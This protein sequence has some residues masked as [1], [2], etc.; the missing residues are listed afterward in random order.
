MTTAFFSQSVAITSTMPNHSLLAS[1][2]RLF[3][4]ASMLHAV[5]AMTAFMLSM[6][7]GYSLASTWG[8]V[9][10]H[11][12]EFLHGTTVAFVAG[13]MLLAARNWSDVREIEGKPLLALTLLWLIPRFLHLYPEWV[14]ATF[15]L[16]ADTL[17]AFLLT[18]IVA[19][20]LLQTRRRHAYATIELLLIY[21]LSVMLLQWSVSGVFPELQESS[22]NLSLFVLVTLLVVLTGKML[23]G[24][25]EKTLGLELAVGRYQNSIDNAAVGSLYLLMLLQLFPDLTLLTGVIAA[26]ASIA[27]AAR[28]KHWYDHGI[29][30]HPLLWILFTGYLWIVIGLM[31]YVL[32]LVGSLP[33][34]TPQHLLGNGIGVLAIGMM[35]RV[36]LQHEQPNQGVDSWVILAFILIHASAVALSLVN[37]FSQTV[38]TRLMLASGLSWMGA[39]G[40]MLW[41]FYPDLIPFRS[42]ASAACDPAP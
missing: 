2:F 31:A 41:R 39:F 40:C 37:L 28:L 19:V 33:G 24:F 21:A 38:E 10:W 23:P 3:V 16:A 42:Q 9:L 15:V 36:L 6:L 13:F 30:R 29:W 8:S 7:Q 25:V 32:T 18:A 14:P 20:P 27:N 26:V 34:S 5:I 17:F 22:E 4:L 1:G 35:A 12:H 11:R